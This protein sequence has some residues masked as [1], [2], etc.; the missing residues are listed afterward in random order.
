MAEIKIKSY[1]YRQQGK[2]AAYYQNAYIFTGLD[3]S[4]EEQARYIA[5]REE[6]DGKYPY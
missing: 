1:K 3:H 5:Q 4:G 2:S 6:G